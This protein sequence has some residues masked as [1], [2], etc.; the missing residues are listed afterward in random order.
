MKHSSKE[1]LTED[2][3]VM[4]LTDDDLNQVTGGAIGVYKEFRDSTPIFPHTDP[5]QTD[6]SSSQQ[7]Q[8]QLSLPNISTGIPEEL[9]GIND[10]IPVDL[11]FNFAQNLNVKD[12]TPLLSSTG[13]TMETLSDSL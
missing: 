4:E 11:A 9:A 1:K 7:Y 10:T 6:T 5:L 3:A 2:Q 12:M 13:I 8:Q